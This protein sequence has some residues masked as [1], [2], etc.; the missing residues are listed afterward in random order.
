LRVSRFLATRGRV[1]TRASVFALLAMAGAAL[2][3]TTV[4]S[5][6]SRADGVKSPFVRIDPALLQA[7]GN[8]KPLSLDTTPVQVMVELA[9]P[10]VAVQVADARK[11]GGD[12]SDAQQES[13]RQQIQSTQDGLKGSFRNH[14]AKVVAQLQSAYNGV[15]V[16]VPR[17]EITN[18]AALQGVVAVHAVKTF[19]IGPKNVHGVPFVNAP[20]AWSYHL[21][22]KRV[23]I[24][25]IDTG[26]DYTHAD[27]GG[28]GTVA[29]FNAAKANSTAP[30]DPRLFGPRAPKVKGGYDFV[31]DAYDAGDPTSVP[32]PDPNPLDCNGHGTH[33]A[34][35]AA[36]LGVLDNGKTYR[37]SYNSKT[38][39][40]HDWNV[41]PGVAPEADLYSYRI[42][43]CAGSSN[44]VDLAIDQAVR[45]HVDVITMSLGSDLGGVDDP[46][47][48]ASEN[49][50]AAGI[51][52]VAA[53]GNA[54][55]SGY[56]VSSPSTGPHVLSVAAMDASLPTYPGARLALSTGASVDTID[57][58]GA[59]LPSG[60][61]GVKVLKN[62]DGT[63]ALGCSLADYAGSAGKVV[64]T[65]RGTCARV[66]RAVYGQQAGAA[67]VVM[68]NSSPAIPP[69]EGPITSNPDT[70]E[71]YNVTIPF[72]GAAGTPEN[73][74]ALLAADGGTTTLSSI[75][76]PNTGYQDVASFSSGGPSNPDSAAKPE[77]IAPGVSVASAGIGTGNGFLIESGTSMA[78]P[79][80]AGVAALVQEAHPDWK[81]AQ[82]KA[83]IANTADP[84][85][86]LDYNVRQSGS[87]VVQADDATT[88]STLATTADGYDSLVFGYVPGT[89]AYT[90]TKTFTLTNTDRR[91]VSYALSVDPDSG[92]LGG[93]AISVSPSSVTVQGNRSQTV[94]VTLTYSAAAF[95]ALPSMGSTGPGE[96]VSFGG[97]IVATP[98]AASPRGHRGHGPG[99]GGPLGPRSGNGGQAQTLRVTFMVVPRGLSN[100]TTGTPV[101]SQVPVTNNG[102]HEGTVDAY[103][104]ELTDP[105]EGGSP[106][107]IRDVGIQSFTSGT[108]KFNVFAINT[109]GRFTNASVN[110][111]DVSVDTNRDGTTD[112]TIAGVDLGAVTTGSFNGQFASFIFNAAGHLVDAWLATAPM[113][114]S[115][116]ELPFLSSNIGMGSTSGAFKYTVTGFSIVPGTLVDTTGSALYDPY[117][118]A[119]TNGQFLDLLPGATDTASRAFSASRLL[120]TPALGLL[121]V[122]L[123]DANGAPQADEVPL[124]P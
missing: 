103:T 52:V 123:D 46:T 63:I 42:F 24:A 2:I 62:A 4:S 102:I 92:G 14:G 15:Q 68:V 88:S 85:L 20:V 95:A 47:T 6:A 31:G 82:I 105:N 36:G 69:Y 111:F 73:T 43:G 7:A 89:G 98:A 10:P 26:L 90:A 30:A 28:P 34:G 3:A 87:G 84:T 120:V 81:G 77:V 124:A 80:T 97:A 29:A 35:T 101:G 113:N 22:G 18:L 12:L 39:T 8:F 59:A 37:G 25:D 38:V 33:T 122:N 32:V 79:M 121:Y 9:T 67:A 13:I 1:R 78:T 99:D 70:G 106:V 94:S 108:D 44:V 75:S 48:V 11:R 5:A 55:P 116:V 100:I 96:V 45:D 19:T 72:L 93:G 107:D 41:G 23:K 53:A 112:Y 71:P 117:R 57:A 86:N 64:V 56:I 58:N 27:F 91:D 60:T 21:T 49:A 66:A 61:F 40:G 110:E 83:A 74:A 65:K 114:G 17:N 16:S 115:V 104:W 118:P 76:I 54:G 109:W 51:T 119:T 50:A